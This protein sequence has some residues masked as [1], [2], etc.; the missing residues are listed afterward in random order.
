[1]MS[2]LLLVFFLF[3][4]APKAFS[5]VPDSLVRRNHWTLTFNPLR[6]FDF[7]NPG[8][9]VGAQYHYGQ[10]S[11]QVG[12][13]SIFELLG[14]E[15]TGEYGR[16]RGYRLFAEQ[17]Y[18][19]S[20][21]KRFDQY[22]AGEVVFQNSNSRYEYDVYLGDRD[23]IYEFID[24]DV[25]TR[26][27]TLVMGNVG[28]GITARDERVFFSFAV[29]LNFRWKELEITDKSF[30]EIYSYDVNGFDR[31]GARPDEGRFFY[32]LPYSSFRVGVLLGALPLEKRQ[33]VR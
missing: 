16:E 12:G 2:R 11:T 25:A 19:L 18:L 15:F 14:E 24:R 7:S 32:V 20:T 22:V 1:M 29:G 10:W 28:Y 31:N 5:Q 6:L 9:L 33:L 23:S 13:I 4:F 30:D 21:S 3:L 8:L 26:N 17:R 27:K